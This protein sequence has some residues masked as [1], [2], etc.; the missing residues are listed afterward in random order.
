[1]PV[2]AGPAYDLVLRGG[3]VIDPS[4]NHEA[5]AD[6]ARK[7]RRRTIKGRAWSYTRIA[8]E[9]QSMGIPTKHGRPWRHSSVVDLIKRQAAMPR[10]VA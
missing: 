5:A 9:L 2:D 6:L 8:Q 7:M 1:M 3:R 10:D 4:Q